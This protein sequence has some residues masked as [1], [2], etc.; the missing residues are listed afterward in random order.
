MYVTINEVKKIFEGYQRHLIVSSDYFMFDSDLILLLISRENGT[1]DET[2]IQFSDIMDIKIEKGRTNH[3]NFRISEN[4]I[5]EIYF[6]LNDLSITLISN[7]LIINDDEYFIV[8]PFMMDEDKKTLK[9]QKS[10]I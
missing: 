5:F 6:L 4:N 10:G 8:D 9:P 2:I 3:Q 1:R 7:T